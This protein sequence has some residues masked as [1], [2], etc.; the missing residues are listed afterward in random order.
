MANEQNLKPWPKGVSGNPAGRP[1]RDK[2]TAAMSELLGKPYPHD[3]LGRTYAER[4]AHAMVLK[5][6]RG[7][8]RAA[9]EIALR[10]EGRPP[11]RVLP[12]PDEDV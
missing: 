5:A 10:T 9:K 8:V 1:S 2:V 7:D 11:R 12:G 4:I 6:C 3:K